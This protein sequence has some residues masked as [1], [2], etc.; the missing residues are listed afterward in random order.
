MTA[1]IPSSSATHSTSLAFLGTAD[2]LTEQVNALKIELAQKDLQITQLTN[3]TRVL[4]A[5]LRTATQRIADQEKAATQALR[6]EEE[7]VHQLQRE[8]TT[9]QARVATLAAAAATRIVV[10]SD[11]TGSSSART[12]AAAY[13]AEIDSQSR[14]HAS[15]ITAAGAAR[16]LA[17][18]SEAADS[19]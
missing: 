13:L 4:E 6:S 2:D 11:T 10:R 9:L 8:A 17:S 19:S 12:G 3:Y 15:A 5:R 18:L 1:S 16:H 14:R 7:H